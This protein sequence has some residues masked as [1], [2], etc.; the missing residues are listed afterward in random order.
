METNTVSLDIAGGREI[1]PQIRPPL[2]STNGSEIVQHR[3]EIQ[4]FIRNRSS[5][6]L[7]ARNDLTKQSPVV[8]T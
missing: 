1:E 8:S 2:Y 5:P 6:D 4:S 7:L 3:I